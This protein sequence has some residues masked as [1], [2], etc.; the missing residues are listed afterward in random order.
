MS[1]PILSRSPI[2]L[3]RGLFRRQSSRY[4]EKLLTILAKVSLTGDEDEVIQ[5]R[6][7]HEKAYVHLRRGRGRRALV[8]A[9]GSAGEISLQDGRGR[10]ALRR[11][12][13]HG[14]YCAHDDG[15]RA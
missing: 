9:F 3:P 2:R 11:R 10:H 1:I 8:A 5:W 7:A 14:H 12:R 15:P 4:I 13:R 6:K